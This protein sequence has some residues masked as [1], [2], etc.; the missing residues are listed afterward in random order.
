MVSNGYDGLF[1]HALNLGKRIIPSYSLKMIALLTTEL[2]S[3]FDNDTYMDVSIN[4]IS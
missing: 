1:R 3:Q 4:A 2:K